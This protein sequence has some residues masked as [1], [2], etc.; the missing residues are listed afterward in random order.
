MDDD[1]PLEEVKARIDQL[2][3]KMAMIFTQKYEQGMKTEDIAKMNRISTNT[4][5]IQLKRAREKIRKI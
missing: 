3:E 4:V 1:E 2:P 5:N